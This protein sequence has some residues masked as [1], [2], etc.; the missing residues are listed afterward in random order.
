[1]TS[2]AELTEKYLTEHSSIK[3]CLKT[4]VINYSRLSRKIA[5]DLGIEKKT[6]MESILVACRRYAAKLDKEKVQE[7]KVLRLLKKSELEIRNKIV[8]AV[9]DKKIYAEHLLEIEKK[10]RK[11]ADTFYAI[12]GTKVFIIITSEKYVEDIH[13]LFGRNILKIT[14]NL[15][16]IIIKSP[17]DMENTHGVV[18]YLYSLFSEHGMNIVETMSC[19]TDTILVVPDKDIPAI[20]EFL[21]F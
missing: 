13:K 5:K 21:K 11:T 12:E 1:M 8:A 6:S 7:E 18:S 9:V 10:I 16:M 15:A 14:K 19:W 20:M 3:D 4:G 17:E 2:T